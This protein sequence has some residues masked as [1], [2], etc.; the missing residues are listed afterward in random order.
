[1]N[2]LNQELLGNPAKTD[3]SI[4]AAGHIAQ[5]PRPDLFCSMVQLY[6]SVLTTAMAP[7]D[8][9]QWRDQ[10]YNPP[11]AEVLA[12]KLRPLEKYF[13][14]RSNDFAFMQDLDPLEDS[15]E[16]PI[17]NLF[18]EMPA[19]GHFVNKG[20]IKGISP[21]WAAIALFGL[22]TNAPSGGRGHRTSLR[23][24]GPLSTLVLPP[25][26]DATLWQTLWLNVLS[27]EQIAL[28]PGD[29]SKTNRLFPWSYPTRTS[30]N[31]E[32]TNPLDCHPLQVLWGMPRRI[33]LVFHNDRGRCDLTGEDCNTLV[34]GFRARHGGT[35]YGGYWLHPHTPYIVDGNKPPL[36]IKGQPGG[37]TYRHW[38]GLA[39][40]DEKAKRDCAQVVSAY[41]R[42]RAEEISAGA[43]A[44]LWISGYD[45]D[46]AKARCWY[47]TTLPLFS[48]APEH[49]ARV[50]DLANKLTAAA[51]SCSSTL[52][53]YVREAALSKVSKAK[54]D[55]NFIGETLLER[56]EHKF[57]ELLQRFIESDDP[58][59]EVIDLK[60]RWRTHLCGQAIAIFDTHVLATAET[61][62]TLAKLTK[63]RIE[64]K[65]ALCGNKTIKTLKKPEERDGQA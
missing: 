5:A 2:I 16:Q 18:M 25:N 27:K 37:V 54:P 62:Q 23:G 36:S 1:M 21:F 38:C 45:M 55:L 39:L 9:D 35:N 47:D 6:I 60:D 63:A 15:E 42:S 29:P 46:N 53:R 40:P 52:T 19:G 61:P 50:T 8:E 58:E 7:E 11:T 3:F 57:F 13:E 44:K 49:R 48:I 51:S 56:T 10:Y 32:E 24:G 14:L 4:L 20:R 64:F 59:N 33:R 26:E 43:A 28:L 22:Q 34:T 17:E 65:R 30:E 31:G 12:E 41:L